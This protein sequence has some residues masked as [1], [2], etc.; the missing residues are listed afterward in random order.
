MGSGISG[1]LY[2]RCGKSLGIS[3]IF[4][5]LKICKSVISGG[6]MLTIGDDRRKISY[7]IKTPD[8]ID[9]YP[10]YWLS[11]KEGTYHIPAYFIVATVPYARP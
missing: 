4:I 3:G 6:D 7:V 1:Y 9:M 8:D 10:P 2:R 5:F 11:S